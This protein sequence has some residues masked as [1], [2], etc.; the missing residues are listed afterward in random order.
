MTQEADQQRIIT[1]FK[2]LAKKY[3]QFDAVN[4]FEEAIE[5]A[6]VSEED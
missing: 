3:G 5:L 1:L 4:M 2:L 6:E